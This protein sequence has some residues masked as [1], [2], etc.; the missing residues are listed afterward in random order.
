MCACF[1]APES[2]LSQQGK[3]VASVS[4]TQAEA[5]QVPPHVVRRILEMI[6]LIL[7]HSKNLPVL[8]KFLAGSSEI[9][10]QSGASNIQGLILPKKHAAKG[11]RPA[12][13]MRRHNSGS[14]HE[15]STP[16][17]ILVSL[18][19]NIVFQRSSALLEHLLKVLETVCRGVE[20]DTPPPLE[21]STPA[22]GGGSSAASMSRTTL[23]NISPVH[24]QNADAN[25]AGVASGSTATPMASTPTIASSPSDR[26][27]TP[28][29]PK[30]SFAFAPTIQR[31]GLESLVG[32]F[33]LDT[34]SDAAFSTTRT[35]IE[36]ISMDERHVVCLLD[37]LTLC[38][39]KHSGEL[40]TD[41]GQLALQVEQMEG[42]SKARSGESG[43]PMES[44]DR[45]EAL[46][47]LSSKTS[48]QVALLRTLKV[49]LAVCQRLGKELLAKDQKAAEHRKA[50]CKETPARSQPPGAADS[51]VDPM[52]TN[53]GS[54]TN[55]DADA[56]ATTVAAVATSTASETAGSV[57]VS[58]QMP[59]P[60]ALVTPNVP[61]QSSG[62][63]NDNN[64]A[65]LQTDN[66]VSKSPYSNDDLTT[67]NIGHQKTVTVSREPNE[68]I[69]MN[70]RSYHGVKGVRVSEVTPGGPIERTGKV[71]LGDI[72]VSINDRQMLDLP[73][74]DVLN[75]LKGCGSTFTL[76]VRDPNPSPAA[77]AVLSPSAALTTV[78]NQFPLST[79]DALEATWQGL[80]SCL[81]MLQEQKH[82]KQM[83]TTL[84]PAI[85]CLFVF[86]QI[87]QPE[88]LKKPVRDESADMGQAPVE[89]AAN[90]DA[91]FSGDVATADGFAGFIEKFKDVINDIIRATPAKL[92]SGP[93]SVLVQHAHILDFRV[94]EAYFRQQL[95]REAHG[96][97]HGRFRMEVRRD[98]IF[99]DSFSRLQRRNMREQLMGKIDVKFVGEEGLDAG[100]LLR[101]WYYKLS[102]EM[103][104]PMYAL[105]KDS[106]IGS[107]TYQPN[108]I[109]GTANHNHLSYFEFC[110]RICAKAIYDNQLLD[111]HFTRAFYKQILGKPVSWHDMQ[112]V[113]EQQHKSLCWILENNVTGLEMTMSMDTEKFG[114]VET[115]DLLPDGQ[116]IE[117]TEDNKMEYVRLICNA[118]LVEV[119]RPQMDAFLKGFQE[120]IPQKDIAI[121]NENEL[122]MIIS[123]LPDVDIDDLKANTEFGTGYNPTS[124]QI[125]WFWRVLRT[126]D[127]TQ[128]VKLVQFIT[129]TGKI[130]VGGFSELVGMSGPQKFNIHKD[131][132][133][134]DR[135]P[136]AHTCFNQLDLPEYTSYEQL[137][138]RLIY[139]ISEGYRS[140]ISLFL[141]FRAFVPAFPCA[142]AFCACC[143]FHLCDSIASCTSRRS[144]NMHF[145]C[146]CA[147][148]CL[149]PCRLQERRLW[150]CL[151]MC[152]MSLLS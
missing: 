11:K 118:K 146:A 55:L 6:L 78:W 69:G 147:C 103:M 99:L 121:F 77:E 52:D 114:L 132:S 28:A 140:L 17:S 80:A 60:S 87:T 41:L 90:A 111:C 25:T 75:E 8:Q 13:P 131:R 57:S 33:A 82:T 20:D 120:L 109:S 100:G 15:S 70:I 101:E 79:M 115:R 35:I 19:S 71:Q 53:T 3:K 21:Q 112:A 86:T 9:D 56:T 134:S 137:R 27:A 145:V 128:R 84:S 136:Q 117:V 37:V 54:A 113:D 139:A 127:R 23:I 64:D 150:L 61:A 110:G 73:H 85:E 31:P 46:D 123:G 12:N 122:E 44:M 72:I 66:A 29:K 94:K 10:V 108:P 88:G 22:R 81:D 148:V 40:S 63:L 96:H 2:E 126:F 42:D 98:D 34:C 142:C 129:G 18:L 74:K 38:C 149:F 36:H 50:A 49:I 39:I 144:L 26:G 1:S 16:I 135:L 47:K 68:R 43:A 30:R 24:E 83:V 4:V 58:D 65:S 91:S 105:F 102:H 124:P 76:V 95:K 141:L 106:N 152:G 92:S 125:M 32:I 89:P 14:K 138:E 107:E 104:N 5:L 59:I 143:T 130:P 48:P 151:R 67:D 93:F 97:R 116:N 51:T 7:A 62:G 119:I 45:P 133:G